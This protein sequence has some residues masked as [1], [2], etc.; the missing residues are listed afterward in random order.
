MVVNGLHRDTDELIEIGMPVFS[1]GASPTGPLEWER[2]PADALQRCRL[3]PWEVTLND[4]LVGDRD[5]VIILPAARLDELV[6]AARTIRD[7]EREQAQLARL[8]TSL[9]QQFGFEDYLARGELD[10]HNPKVAGSNPAPA[11][12]R[13][14]SRQMLRPGS[15]R[16]W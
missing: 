13:P 8:G 16:V 5:G 2:G 7:R 4:V 14:W 11:T 9:R 12:N 6:A 3:G 15:S 10:P 1:L